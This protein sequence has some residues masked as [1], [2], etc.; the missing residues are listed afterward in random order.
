MATASGRDLVPTDDHT[1]KTQMCLFIVMHKDGTPFETTSIMEEDIV[2]F[3]VMLGHIHPLGVLQ[4]S[5]TE[6]VILFHTAAEIQQASCGTPKVTEL[7]NK[8]ITM[9][10]VAPTEPQV[11]VY[12]Q[13]GGGYP[14]KLWSL[15]SE[16]EE[17]VNSPIGNP[18]WGGVLC[19][20]FRCIKTRGSRGGSPMGDCT[21]WAA[22]T[23]QQFAITS[24]G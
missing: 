16:E 19:N 3:C 1:L 8:L 11:K 7:C 4:Y 20:A 21:L 13:V 2:Q 17:D 23:P 12:I 10:I 22:C 15:P 14:P 6:S 18:D 9:K 5:A 24:L